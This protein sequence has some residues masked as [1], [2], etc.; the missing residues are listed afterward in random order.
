MS[1]WPDSWYRRPGSDGGTGGDPSADKTV[2]IS[3][4]QYARGQAGAGQGPVPPG[5]WPAQP[6]ASSAGGAG[7][8]VQYGP[9]GSA[10]RYGGTAAPQRSPVGPGQYGG[11]SR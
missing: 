3:A 11:G 5:A 8:G 4:D 1:E 6:P 9:G 7:Y 2:N 10:N